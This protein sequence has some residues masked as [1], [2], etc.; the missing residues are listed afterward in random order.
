MPATERIGYRMDHL[1]SYRVGLE[2]PPEVVGPTPEALRVN[3]YLAGGEIS[4]PRVSGTIRPVGADWLVVRPDG[5]GILDLR[6]TYETDDGALIYA[7][8]SGVLDLGQNGLK[9]LMAGEMAPDGTPFRSAPRYVTAH[10]DYAWLNRL[11]CIGIGQIF[12]SKAEVRCD[13]YAVC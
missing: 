3:F 9:A 8:F 10:P 13:V 4:G 7:P 12:P 1:F 5:V 11:Q 2:L 6:T